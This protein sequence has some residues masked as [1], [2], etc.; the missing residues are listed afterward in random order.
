MDQVG[1]DTRTFCALNRQVQ[2][3]GDSS[4]SITE[5]LPWTIENFKNTKNGRLTFPTKFDMVDD[6][7][8]VNHE[9]KVIVS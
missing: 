2:E 9:G 6:I 5:N 7:L 3:T 8:N 4:Q 1:A